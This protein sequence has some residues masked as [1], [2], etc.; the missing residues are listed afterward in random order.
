MYINTSEGA[1]KRGWGWGAVRTINSTSDSVPTM[2]K[3]GELQLVYQFPID[4]LDETR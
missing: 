1:H 3:R 2:G 4:G